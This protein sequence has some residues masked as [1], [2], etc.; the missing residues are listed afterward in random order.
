MVTSIGCAAFSQLDLIEAPHSAPRDLAIPPDIAKQLAVYEAPG[1]QSVL[2]PLGWACL[3]WQGSSGSTL[4]VAPELP[5]HP[6]QA[7][8]VGP[9]IV[10]RVSY[11]D[12]SGLFEVAGT[13]ARLF[14]DKGRRFMPEL[15]ERGLE[16][17]ESR[18][19]FEPYP[20]DHLV[21]GPAYQVEFVTPA[22]TIGLGSPSDARPSDLPSFGFVRYSEASASLHKLVVRLT[23]D[24][25]AL[26]PT[27]MSESRL[28]IPA[29]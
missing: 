25:D 4:V 7:L 12:T 6:D 11:A 27:I 29:R 2:G 24:L 26:R 17:P 9:A 28:M 8:P 23:A 3:S 20:Q 14:P 18:Y 10:V 1:G 19:V 13:M 21:Y 22:S 5:P 15:E 16:A